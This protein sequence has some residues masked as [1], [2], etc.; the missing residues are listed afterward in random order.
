[1][2]ISAEQV[3]D[4]GKADEFIH[5]ENGMGILSR[6]G[7]LLL[8][9]ASIAALAWA[10]A[11]AQVAPAP[12]QASDG[13]ALQEIVVTAQKR[14]E[15]ANKVPMSITVVTGDQLISAGVT[16]PRD[17]VKLTP[18]FTYADSLVGSPIYTLR[19]VGFSD[20]SLGGRPTVS[21]YADEAPIPFAIETRGANLD[22][23]RVEV[24]KGPQGT[25]FGQNATGGAINYIDAKPSKSLEGGINASYGNFNA[26]DIGGYVSGPLTDTLA[27]RLAVDHSYNDGWQKSYTTGATNGVGDF[28]NG[29]LL[30]RWTPIDRLSVNLNINGYIDHSD[31]QAAQLINIQPNLPAYAANVPGLLNY[32]LAPANDRAA[33]FTPGKDY[34]KHNGFFQSNLRTDYAADN[35]LT[36]TA[37]TAYSHYTERQLQDDDGTTLLNVSDLTRGKIDSISQELRLSGNLR[38]RGHFVGGLNYAH[39]RAAENTYLELPQSTPAFTFAAFGLPL[40][41]TVNGTNNQDSTTTAAFANADYNV[42]RD[43]KLYGGVRYT[44]SLDKFNGC[45]ADA[46]DGSAAED[47]GVLYNVFRGL[48]GL[49]PNPPIAAGG[50]VTANSN[51]VSGLVRSSL[52][53]GNVSWRVG[54][55][56]T[57]SDKS[58]VYA[59]ISKGYKAGGFPTLSATLASQLTPARQ[60]SVVAYE[61]GFKTTLMQRTLQLNGAAFYYDYSNKQ[62]LGRVPD[63]VFGPLLRLIN[64]PKSEIAGAELQLV[65][66][67]VRGLTFSGGGTY[68]HSIVLDNFTNYDPNGVLTNMNG[69]SFPNT[70]RWQL[71]GDGNYQWDLTQALTGFVGGNITYQSSTNSQLGDLSLLRIRSYGL[72]D[73]RAG[74]ETKSGAWR[75]TVWGRNVGNVYY[76]TGSNRDTDTTIRFAGMPATYGVTLAYRYK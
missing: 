23:E 68:I 37:I 54:A 16:Q 22:L 71:V 8:A 3:T 40:F 15:S 27:V 51:Y 52:N 75:V 11:L 21:I 29:R 65:W 18:G 25:L 66:A 20:I 53:E 35:G 72:V 10:P 41:A 50:C 17:L 30:L 14:E 36:L 43:V 33:D 55:E 34:R 74:M 13:N 2:L 12:G 63:P 31:T 19:G 49:A 61:G 4:S 59:N 6:L 58:L 69:E 9:G 60:E 48:A 28:T 1:M 42:W 45:T 70:P 24:L 39:D 57:P 46:G 67:P 73:L 5:P 38:D 64:V 47:F 7:C 76:W 44:R 56:W 62:I 26:S 32:P